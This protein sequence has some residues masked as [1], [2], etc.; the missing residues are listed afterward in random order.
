MARGAGKTTNG[1]L[2][3][4]ALKMIAVFCMVVDHAT[5]ATFMLWI[6]RLMRLGMGAKSLML[7]KIFLRGLGRISFPLFAFLLVEGFTHTKN[8]RKYA[9][10]L[11]LFGILSECP[12]DLAI[13]QRVLEFSYQNVFFTLF[14]GLMTLWG[15]E[16]YRG[17][18]GPQ[19]L[20]IAVGAVLC[21]G[22]R[23]DYGVY[24]L[25]IILSMYFFK[26]Q[27]FKRFLGVAAMFFLLYVAEPLFEALSAGIPVKGLYLGAGCWL[28]AMA[29]TPFV[30]IGLY[31]GK[32]GAAFPKYIFYAFYPAH[33][34]LLGLYLRWFA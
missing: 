10:S 17:K 32:R 23:T 16:R 22:L 13:F 27:P 29:L 26:N 7:L 8:L 3:G 31:N 20:V 4:F 15:L 2:T 34:L 18:R 21:W 30:P 9:A 6:P 14:I 11:L 25:G 19:G 1:V 24:G 12:F 33:L 28:F 5:E